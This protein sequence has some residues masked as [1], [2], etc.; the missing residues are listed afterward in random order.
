MSKKTNN[1]G[2]AIIPSAALHKLFK[3]G[4]L[5]VDAVALFN[6]YYYT[7]LWQKTNKPMA[8]RSYVKK[9]FG[10][11]SDR[12]YYADRLLKDSG[13]IGEEREVK[14]DEKGLFA[15]SRKSK[16]KKGGSYTEIKNYFG[17]AAIVH[18]SKKGLKVRL[19]N[20]RKMDLPISPTSGLTDELSVSPPDRQTVERT[21]SAYI[22]DTIN[23]LYQGYLER[24]N[25]ISQTQKVDSVKSNKNKKSKG[26][27][28]TV[29]DDSNGVPAN[30]LASDNDS[31]VSDTEQRLVDHALSWAK[32][33][34]RRLVGSKASEL[35]K[36]IRGKLGD[37][38][39][40][41]DSLEVA[42][43]ALR[44]AISN[45]YDEWIHT[46]TYQKGQYGLVKTL[47]TQWKNLTS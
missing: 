21:T 10:W 7:G 37:L 27:D 25:R 3:H 1:N 16:T 35:R 2:Y 34:E 26:K 17:D 23:C 12:F 33:T 15:G 41:G 19:G 45:F 46:D 4:K 30:Q 6:F 44:I 20:G 32:Y 28:S 14:R 40:N 29:I 36:F 13:L 43:E 9:V 5:G 47:E 42:E 39:K 24:D 38:T 18:R 11:G 8:T 31:I 22:Q